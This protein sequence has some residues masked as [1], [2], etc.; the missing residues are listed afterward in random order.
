MPMMLKAES[1]LVLQCSVPT[2]DLIAA[3][4]RKASL[5][6]RESRVTTGSDDVIISTFAS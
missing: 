6:A 1:P 2:P 5:H 4:V 3:K